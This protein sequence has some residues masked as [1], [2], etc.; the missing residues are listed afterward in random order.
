MLVSGD[1]WGT[2][3]TSGAM[4]RSVMGSKAVSGSIFTFL[5]RCR[6]TTI[7]PWFAMRAV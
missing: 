2:T 7:G 3:T 4:A 1:S 6:L 5:N